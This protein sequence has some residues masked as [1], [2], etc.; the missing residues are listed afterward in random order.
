MTDENRMWWRDGVVYQIYPRSFADGNGDGIGDLIGVLDHLDYL[1]ELGVEAIWLSPIYPSPDVDFGYDVADYT[2]IDPKFGTMEDFDRLVRE[3]HRRGIRIVLD[4]VLNHTS[5]QH[6]WFK[7]SA[8]TKDNPRRDWYIWRD[9]RPGG[10]PPNNWQSVFGGPAWELDPATGQYYYHMF[11]K[12]QPDLNWR[13]PAVRKEMLDVFRFW[14]E[15]G[16]DGFRLDVFNL[17]F[18]HPEMPDNPPKLGLRGFDRQHHHLRPESAGDDAA[19]G[20]DPGAAG[21]LPGALRDWRD[22]RVV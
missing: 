4:L 1:E 8:S 19:A 12:E 17:Y 10:G 16:V 18:K 15:R 9:P 22:F 11:Y 3:A 14:L 13:N 5:D 7:E 21:C 20:G 6:P 2:A